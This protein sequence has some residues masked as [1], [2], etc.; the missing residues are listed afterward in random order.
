PAM[1]R[2]SVSDREARSLLDTIESSAQRAARIIRQLLTFSR[3]SEGQRTPVDCSAIIDD[4]LQII[5]ETFPRN[6][7][8][9]RSG[10]ATSWTVIGDATQ[11]H[12]VLMN[13]CVNARDEMPDGGTL[14][15]RLENMEVDA[16]LARMHPGTRPGRFVVVSVTD[17]GRGI[18]P[19]HMDK[20]FE[21]FFTTKGVGQGTGLGLATALGIV[22]THGG[23][24]QVQSQLGRGSE[25]KIYLPASSVEQRPETKQKLEP[26]PRGHGELVLVV[27]DEESIRRVTRAMLES[28]GYRVLLATSGEE[29]LAIHREK[30]GQLQLILSD[31]MMPGMDGEALVKAIRAGDPNVRLIVMSG[32][33]GANGQH[34]SILPLIQGLLE[35][36]F[37]MAAIL[38]TLSEVLAAG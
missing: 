24:I 6:I 14:D 35:K 5:R 3:G 32:D 38:R 27:D 18:D 17:D 10:L 12:Q 33:A 26:F 37:T 2:P 19:G 9:R 36:P 21:P 28:N 25:F 20:L 29:A 1:L 23:F 8:A 30:H 11:L 13:L 34:L 31:L 4:M 16:L 15:L 22:K 7:K